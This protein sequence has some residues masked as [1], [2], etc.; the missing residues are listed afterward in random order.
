MR[1][2]SQVTE[3]WEDTVF[4]WPQCVSVWM[5]KGI[6]FPCAQRT[7]EGRGDDPSGQ[8]PSLGICL[9]LPAITGTVDVQHRTPLFTGF[10]WDPDEHRS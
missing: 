2:L 1:A 3:L 4:G 9:S 8:Q 5:D 7:G 6:V 10:L